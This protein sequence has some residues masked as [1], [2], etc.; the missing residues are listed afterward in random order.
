[1]LQL[2]GG[3]EVCIDT[4][5]ILGLGISTALMACADSGFLII[6][7]MCDCCRVQPAGWVSSTSTASQSSAQ[8]A[9]VWRR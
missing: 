8:T 5:R 7:G 6:K 2:F 4:F 3:G 1:M 9:S